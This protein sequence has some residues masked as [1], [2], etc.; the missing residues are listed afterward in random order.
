MCRVHSMDMIHGI[1][2]RRISGAEQHCWS[3]FP[4]SLTASTQTTTALLLWP[5]LLASLL[6]ELLH[7]LKELLL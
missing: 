1:C 7:C 3:D 6:R 5:L 2:Y 4:C